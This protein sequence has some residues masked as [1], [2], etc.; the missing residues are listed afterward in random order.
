MWLR[1]GP[2]YCGPAGTAQ[3]KG[4]AGHPLASPAPPAPQAG[5]EGL[6]FAPLLPY[7]FRKTLWWY[8][9]AHSQRRIWHKHLDPHL[10]T[11]VNTSTHA[12]MPVC[13][14][15]REWAWGCGGLKTSCDQ[16]TWLPAICILP[17]HP[18]RA[19][20]GSTQGGVEAA[21]AWA[22]NWLHTASCK[23]VIWGSGWGGRDRN[24]N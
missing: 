22:W 12:D 20:P 18:G 23:Y 2:Q 11:S 17:P 4:G 9:C 14:H 3:E 6:G 1:W 19:H 15:T 7:R 10:C 13:A 5:G 24:I 16:S 21:L 8:A